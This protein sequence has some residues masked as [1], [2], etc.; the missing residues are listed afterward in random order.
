MDQPSI[1]PIT[2]PTS[3]IPI[4]TPSTDFNVNKF[5]LEFEQQQREKQLQQKPLQK[6]E[7]IEPKK[8]HQYTIGELILDYKDSIVN[9]IDDLVMFRFNNLEDLSNIFLKDNRLLHIGI[10]I[11]ILSIFLYIFRNR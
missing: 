4:R 1:T 9:I 8:L 2:T 11:I 10:T 3:T 6:T 5:N 7:Y